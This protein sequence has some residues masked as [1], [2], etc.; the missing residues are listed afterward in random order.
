MPI[1]KDLRFVIIPKVVHPW[2]EEVNKGALYQA[3]LLEKQ[4]VSKL[5]SNISHLSRQT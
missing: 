3:E 5:L 4:L 2:F 1:K